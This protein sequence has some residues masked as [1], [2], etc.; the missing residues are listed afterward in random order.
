[1]SAVASL[2][3]NRSAVITGASQGLGLEIARRYL[4]AGASLVICA[5]D[6]ERLESAASELRASAR[7]GQAVLA[8]PAD[9][10]RPEDVS[11]LIDTALSHLGRLDILV[12]NAGVAGPIGPVESVDWEAWLQVVQI[13][14]LGAVLLSRAV[15]PHLRRAGRGKIV[16]L[17]GGGATQPLPMQSAYAASK[18][19]VIRFVETLAEETRP[20]RI[21]VNAVAPGPLNTRML[22][23]F[24]AAGEASVGRERYER[25]LQQKQQ[26][27][28]PL[29]K[30]AD[31]AVFLG[32]DLSDG[33]TGKLLSAVWDPWETL[34]RHLEELN[35][36]DVYTLR[37]IVA[38]DRQLDF[39]G[40]P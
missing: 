8:V 34:P 3:E 20:Y 37:R 32:S 36:T 28:V 4:S 40:G 22:D 7:P 31:L 18:A 6:A 27:G 15:L 17:S 5:R 21:D 26:G 1:M 16:Q 2:L 14:L 35:R 25:W 24:L 9:I 13:N 11:G 12:N 19:A 30:G 33:I 39:E 29:A 10:S 23:Q 38:H